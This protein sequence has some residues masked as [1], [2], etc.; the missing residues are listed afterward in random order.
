MFQHVLV[1]TDFSG[2]AER[3]L[4]CACAIA[5]R[6]GSTLHLIHVDEE[7]AMGMHSSD[8]LIRFM[9]EVDQK[10]KDWMEQM[11]SQLTADGLSVELGRLE[12]VASEQILVYANQGPIDLI[13]M[14]TTGHTRLKDLLLGSTSS[15][16]LRQ[17][18]CAVLTVRAEAEFEPDW[19]VRR[20]LFPTDFSTAS[21][22]GAQLVADLARAFE[23]EVE[24]LHVLKAPSWVPAMPGEP[25]H[26]S[27]Q[28]FATAQQ[29]AE[30]DLQALSDLPVFQGLKVGWGA[31][32]A[33]DAAEG[34]AEWATEN[35]C[36][37]VV[38]PRHG[39]GALRSI[40]FGRVVQH[41]IRR[42]P[43]PVLSFHP[44]R[45]KTAEPGGT[46]A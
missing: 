41:V 7:R 1:P 13:V 33:G 12:G 32:L 44:T 16:V 20:V 34:I 40:L 30:N 42:C 23:A 45:F 2:G 31:T 5:R 24:L 39:R 15:A 10:R 35:D 36:Q 3:S 25:L 4:E 38:I 17:A 37:L 9:T 28:A 18:D 26:V 14:G 46:G 6:F 43:I 19:P 21:I 11:A 22:A 27:P 8:D 29:R